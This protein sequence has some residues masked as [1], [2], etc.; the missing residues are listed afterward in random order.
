[1]NSPA[2]DG[3]K[4]NTRTRFYTFVYVW[5]EVGYDPA[6]QTNMGGAGQGHNGPARTIE[7]G[8]ALHEPM[9]GASPTYGRA[10]RCP[11]VRR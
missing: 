4:V 3:G 9:R 1:M 8:Y 5:A 10:D 2:F 11:R 6:N 7:S